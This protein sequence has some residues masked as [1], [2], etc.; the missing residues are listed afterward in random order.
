MNR[1]RGPNLW[2]D[3]DEVKQ[4]AKI[5]MHIAHEQRPED[6]AFVRSR[7]R[8]AI[9]RHLRRQRKH[10]IGRVSIAAAMHVPDAAET[11]RAY[12]AILLREIL[13]LLPYTVKDEVLTA[14]L[15]NDGKRIGRAGRLV[16][17]TLPGV[18]TEEP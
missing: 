15:S 10:V 14:L 11:Q 12:E 8:Q 6:L 18:T 2:Y 1:S 13:D 7:A 5:A 9:G 17:A 16:R 3:P 4:E